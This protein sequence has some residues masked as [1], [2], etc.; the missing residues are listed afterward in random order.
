MCSVSNVIDRLTEALF[1]LESSELFLHLFIYILCLFHGD[2]LFSFILSRGRLARSCLI[3]LVGCGQQE[4][5]S[6]LDLLRSLA[7]E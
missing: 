4:R 2:F 3:P 7:L 5:P 1:V 6:N